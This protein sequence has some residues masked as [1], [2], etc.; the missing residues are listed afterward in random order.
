MAAA[1]PSIAPSVAH[2][3]VSYPCLQTALPVPSLRPTGPDSRSS[4]PSRLS[5]VH[6]SPTTHADTTR[7][8]GKRSVPM[9]AAS[10]PATPWASSLPKSPAAP[11]PVA[12]TQ[13]HKAASFSTGAASRRQ[14]S[15]PCST[16]VPIPRTS[17]RDR[18]RRW[19]A[20]DS[21]FAGEDLLLSKTQCEAQL[22]DD[23]W[24]FK[25][26]LEARES[27]EAAAYESSATDASSEFSSLEGAEDEPAELFEMDDL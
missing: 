7:M 19:S 12:M 11:H 1:S 22:W 4:F 23:D 27:F 15:S 16:P 25:L 10:L 2:P 9:N 17:S 26:S 13:F 3:T 18:Q 21:L 14:T 24:H 8:N 5:T 20:S 6:D